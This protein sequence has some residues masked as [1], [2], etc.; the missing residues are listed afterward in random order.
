MTAKE[1]PAVSIYILQPNR[2]GSTLVTR[3]ATSPNVDANHRSHPD[4]Q[5]FRRRSPRHA[6]ADP[7]MCLSI[8][9]ATRAFWG[10]ED[11][12]AQPL[13][14]CPCL[15]LFPAAIRT[16]PQHQRDGTNGS[17]GHS[18]TTGQG[19]ERCV[20]LLLCNLSFFRSCA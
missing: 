14:D 4:S 5:Q 16:K 12:A 19:G 3:R 9:G 20:T 13:L 15:L 17:D 2:H 7:G 18:D 8:S 10:E 11:V 1:T 6:L